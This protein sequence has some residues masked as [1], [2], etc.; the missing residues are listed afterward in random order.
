V[1]LGVYVLATFICAVTAVLSWRHRG[2]T[3][4]A[5]WLAVAMTGLAWWSAVDALASV[6]S[7][8]GALSSVE[9][10]IF[11]GVGTACAGFACLCWSLVDRDWRP[12][13]RTL[14]LVVE[15]VLISV[16]ALTNVMHELVV[17]VGPDP[18]VRSE[19]GPLFWVHAVYSN[20][21]LGAAL[22]HVLRARRH[23][24]ALRTRQ[25]TTVLV[26][27][28]VCV[29][30][31]VV[32]VLGLT[33]GQ[34]VSALGFVLAG[35]VNC[36][37][38][39]RQGLFE[40]I[41]IARARVLEE[42]HDAVL[43]LDEQDRLG[44]VNAAAV[45][46]LARA[47]PPGCAA[48]GTPAEQA[49]G[50][51]ASVLL[52][53]GG[54]HAVLLKDGPADLDL[55]VAELQDRR[56][57]SLG[58]VLVVR[59]VSA[60]TAQRDLLAEANSSLQHE[61][62]TVER[63]RAEVAELARRDPLTGCYN[64]RHLADVLAL[65]V[66]H[67]VETGEELSV[68]ML[69]VDLFK[70]VNDTYGHAVGDLLL[71]SLSQCLQASARATDTVARYGG[72]EFVLVLPRTSAAEALCRAQQIRAQCAL[73]HVLVPAGTLAVTLSAG[74]GTTTTR[75]QSPQSLLAAA[76]DALYRAKDAGRDCAMAPLLPV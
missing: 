58:R 7:T 51:L 2:R 21:L 74:V 9:L 69:D 48:I 10:G 3:P 44:D 39:F 32:V 22:L 72:E 5:G 18:S 47:V 42:L 43:V 40:V 33:G 4:S 71:Q 37:S 54:E 29:S 27:A 26:S 11:P 59:D 57:R 60:A 25:L 28:L 17:D 15:P 12:T 68:V 23:A 14:L 45:A 76:D 6:A 34:D 61:V 50:G 67:A 73:V 70:S 46:L 8:P 65:Q 41:P 56:G 52:S 20:L 24:A 53:R 1:W 38:V 36:Y 30:F 55:Q 49:L 16:A 64:R 31:N 19:F 63:L 75:V 13:R 62:A 66:D 35:L